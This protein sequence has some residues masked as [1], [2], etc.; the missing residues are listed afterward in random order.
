[1]KVVG[2]IPARWGSTRL[3]GKA[4]VPICGRPLI[5]WVLEAAGKANNLDM[6]LVAT[7]DRRIA[8]VVTELGGRAVMTRTDHP[9]GTDRIAEAVARVKANI[10]IN[11][12]GDEPLIDPKLIDSLVGVMVKG[13]KWDMATAAAPIFDQKELENPSVVKVVWDRTGRALYFSPVSDSICEGRKAGGRR[14]PALATHRY[15]RLYPPISRTARQ[16]T[17][18]RARKSGKAGTIE[19]VGYWRQDRGDS[20]EG[21]RN[22]R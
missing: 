8:N 18:V 20:R 9:S 2:V 6:L 22:R 17:P 15:I 13:K 21:G 12:Q 1:M 5:Q 7:D 10:I 19:G 3:P 4:L 14:A 11:I 16:D